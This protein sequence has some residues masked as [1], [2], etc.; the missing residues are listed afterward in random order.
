MIQRPPDQ[1]P[2]THSLF[3]DSRR[4]PPEGISPDFCDKPNPVLDLLCFVRPCTTI[5]LTTLL[6]SQAR[7]CGQLND[8][9]CRRRR[10]PV[11]IPPVTLNPVV[12]RRRAESEHSI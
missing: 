9:G 1:R 8:K 10:T 4:V 12:F 5:I 11:Y 2:V 3:F 7:T 6:G